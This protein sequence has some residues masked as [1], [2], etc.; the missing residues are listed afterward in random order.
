MKLT[1]ML[2]TLLLICVQCKKEN[3]SEDN[4]YSKAKAIGEMHNEILETTLLHFKNLNTKSTGL[5]KELTNA[6]LENY[7]M[8]TYCKS[9]EEKKFLS[10]SIDKIKA[11]FQLQKSKYSTKEDYSQYNEFINKLKQNNII[12]DNG[13]VNLLEKLPDQDNV[14][15]YAVIGYTYI[16]S[17]KYWSN[18]DNV[19]MWKKILDDKLVITKGF[20]GDLWEKT[21]EV[22]GY[23]ASAAGCAMAEAAIVAASGIGAPVAATGIASTA[24]FGSIWSLAQNM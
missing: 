6:K 20:W 13:L 12:D 1:V 8:K 17:Y 16:Y 7:F 15:T 22:A 9:I 21:K 3:S 18:K 24:A 4:L 19:I 11:E 14:S 2:F 5:N 23:D 10:N